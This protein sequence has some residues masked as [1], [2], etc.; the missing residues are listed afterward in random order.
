MRDLNTITFDEAS[1]YFRDPSYE[2]RLSRPRVPREAIKDVPSKVGVPTR[3]SLTI[4]MDDVSPTDKVSP[5]D[6]LSP[7]KDGVNDLDPDAWMD[8]LITGD[9]SSCGT[10]DYSMDTLEEEKII[11]V[12]RALIRGVYGLSPQ[13]PLSISSELKVVEE[14]D[15]INQD[16]EDELDVHAKKRHGHEC[17]GIPIGWF[18]TL[19]DNLTS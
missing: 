17:F 11:R 13:L 14:D 5:G 18:T 12:Q 10:L 3:I 8:D 16:L 6:E 9:D 19:V 1:F 7:M 15:K 4:S 2:K